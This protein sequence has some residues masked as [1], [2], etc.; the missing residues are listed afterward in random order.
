[1]KEG[2]FSP[3][4]VLLSYMD[5][6]SLPRAT[7]YLYALSPAL[8]VLRV[9]EVHKKNTFKFHDDALL[10]DMSVRLIVPRQWGVSSYISV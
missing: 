8:S 9:W 5:L 3:G 10:A 7:A 4:L 6:G 2:G 1:M